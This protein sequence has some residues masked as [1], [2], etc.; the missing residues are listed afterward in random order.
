MVATNPEAFN[1]TGRIYVYIYIC[2]RYDNLKRSKLNLDDIDLELLLWL[3]WISPFGILPLGYRRRKSR[4]FYS[5]NT[6]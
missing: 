3:H 2:Y 5:A 4:L 1:G 6:S